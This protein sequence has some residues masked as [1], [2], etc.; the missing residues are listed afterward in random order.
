MKITFKKADIN[1]DKTILFKFEEKCFIRKIDVRFKNADELVSYLKHMIAYFAILNSEIA[2]YIGY[3]KKSKNEIELIAIAVLPEY[4]RKGVATA[5]F[6]K[7]MSIEKN[8]TTS[9][10]T[11]PQNSSAL[12]F[13]LR[14]GFLI[15]QW[16]ENYFGD[17]QPRLLLVKEAD[18]K[19]LF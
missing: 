7:L 10:V 2:G 17:G 19:S 16:K 13:Y 12:I 15:N 3:E 11:H 8:M 1:K 6:K 9:L 14:N 5:L 4:Q 18:N